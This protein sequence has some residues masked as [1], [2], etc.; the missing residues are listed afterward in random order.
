C[1]IVKVPTL[2]RPAHACQSCG[3]DLRESQSPCCPECGW[4][5]PSALRRYLEERQ[6]SR[7][8]RGAGRTARRSERSARTEGPSTTRSC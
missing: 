4:H 1:G 5:L 8:D 6:A 2:Q 3:Y 7:P